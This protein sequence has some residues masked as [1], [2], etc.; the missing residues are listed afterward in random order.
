MVHVGMGQTFTALHRFSAVNTQFI[1]TDGAYPAAALVVSTN[2]LYSTTSQ[3]GSAGGGTV[4]KINPDGTG[5]AVL[6]NFTPANPS[7]GAAGDGAFPLG[8]LV[9]S[10]Q[11]LYGTTSAG[12]GSNNGIVFKISTAGSNFTTLHVFSA[13]DPTSG[14]N[15]DGSAPWAGLLLSGNVL[16]GTATR[17]GDAGSGTIFKLNTDGTG[18]TRLHS[19]SALDASTSTN[20]DGA[21]PLGGLAL[22]GGTLYGT[23][24]RGGGAGAGT[25]YKI[26]V[27]GSGFAV[28]QDSDGGPRATLLLSSNTLY[29][30]TET[31]GTNSGGTVFKLNTDGTGLT[32]LQE[33]ATGTS[34]WAGL[35]FFGNLLCGTT[36]GGGDSG[37]GSVFGL[38]TD[39]TGFTNLYSFSGS[40]DGAQ[41]QAGLLALGSALYGT[42]STGGT[43]AVGTIFALS[44][45]PATPQQLSIQLLG[46]AVVLSWAS[47]A[48]GLAL[49][50]ATNL[51]PPV[52]W[53]HVP[54]S[55]AIVNGKN[56]M[57][58]AI[59]GRQ[60]FYR[61]GP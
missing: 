16:Y 37:Q 1:N 10:D 14:A 17:G 4:F 7:T 39:G 44:L 11:T 58:N 25:I 22:S 57:T 55:P 42:A 46:S 56:V 49:Q 32:N 28:L 52:V 6:H 29:G 26:N 12:G 47:D 45:G 40:A 21:Y 43:S 24:Y 13:S 53:T 33:F 61:L 2:I 51:V 5:F 34:P 60:E 30:T 50:S 31:G 54:G 19:F 27:D 9:V 59:T 18:F 35:T 38:N 3:G 23:T 41:P 48:T 15:S 20:S 36:Y 8:S